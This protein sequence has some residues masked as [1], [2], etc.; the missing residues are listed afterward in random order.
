MTADFHF[1][2][3]WWF[4]LLPLP[5]LW[6]LHQRRS[7]A[8]W[9][10]LWSPLT[11]RFPSLAHLQGLE[12]NGDAANQRSRWPDHLLLLSLIFSI[13]ALSQP[14][15][16]SA[17][18]HDKKS[19]EPVDLIL[20]VGTAVTM[21]LRDYMAN[22]ERVSRMTMVRQLLDEFVEDYSGQRIGLVILG[23]PPAIWLPLTTDKSVVKNAISR[24]R[25]TLGGRLSDTGGAL[26]LIARQFNS[27]DK[28]VVVLVTDAGL[29]LGSHSPEEGAALLAKKNMKLYT[30]AIGSADPEAGEKGSTRLI[31]EPVNIGLMKKLA[32]I[33]H[34]KMFQALDT[35]TMQQALSTIE[36][37]ERQPARPATSYQLVTPLYP[38]PLALALCL[39]AGSLIMAQGWFS[40][41]SREAKS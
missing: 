31:Y 18:V 41:T 40:P 20:L 33:G 16:N 4:L 28:K 3:P 30:I 2:Q 32:A 1:L 8:Q 15:K 38:W 9:P 7:A 25:T 11:L 17:L 34:G 5:F 35:A 36:T 26:E 24:I 39:L 22:G 6:W 13:L 29:Q 12:K 14:V 10:A 21:D 27:P 19:A 23:D 37:N